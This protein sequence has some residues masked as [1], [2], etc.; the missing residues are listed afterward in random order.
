MDNNNEQL[1]KCSHCGRMLPVSEFYKNSGKKDGL[2]NNCKE[3]AKKMAK[4]YQRK[5][6]EK[7]EGIVE[8]K[9]N[10]PLSAYTPRELM[11]EISRRGYD[12]SY[13]FV[14]KITVK[15]QAV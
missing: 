6:R 12:A 4:T 9:S 2:S 11:E 8:F 13:T 14:K 1:K 5:N 15:A 10:N 3:C 7:E